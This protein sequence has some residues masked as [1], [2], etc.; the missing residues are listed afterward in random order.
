[1]CIHPRCISV[2]KK[3]GSKSR[4]ALSALAIGLVGVSTL[5][6]G[7]SMPPF[8]TKI[9]QFNTEVEVRNV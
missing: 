6:F 9:S 2:I 8:N 3:C 7:T 5:I 4:D 1:L